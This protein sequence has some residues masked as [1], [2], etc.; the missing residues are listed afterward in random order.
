MKSE[1]DREKKEASAGSVHASLS[2]PRLLLFSTKPEASSSGLLLLPRWPTWV[3]RDRA[4]L[5]SFNMTA[6]EKDKLFV[7]RAH[8]G[9]RTSSCAI[10]SLH[11][12]QV[13]LTFGA[14][15]HRF[16][17]V[18]LCPRRLVVRS[19]ARVGARPLLFVLPRR[20][21]PRPASRLG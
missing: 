4:N 17:E 15:C 2:S 1:L 9:S 8:A 10:D 5:E 12:I 19:G 11:D 18:D 21:R 7:H 6:L 3:Q 13:R 14:A 16:F 20:C